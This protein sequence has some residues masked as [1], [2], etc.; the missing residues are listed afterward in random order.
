ML[1]SPLKLVNKNLASLISAAS[2][3]SHNAFPATPSNTA[4]VKGPSRLLLHSC[5]PS[6]NIKRQ[7][8]LTSLLLS[9]P[10][11]QRI[12]KMLMLSRQI[13]ALANNHFGHNMGEEEVAHRLTSLEHTYE[14][15]RESVER[16]LEEAWVGAGCLAPRPSTFPKP[17]L[18]ASQYPNSPTVDK[19]LKR[20]RQQ[21][22]IKAGKR[23][24]LSD[25]STA[26]G[27]NVFELPCQ[28]IGVPLAAGKLGP[29]HR[30]RLRMWI[31]KEAEGKGRVREELVSPMGTRLDG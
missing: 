16:E 9:Q 2:P 29:D 20:K 6:T 21:D 10:L 22:E 3:R 31:Y 25:E 15:V 18:P 26:T 27:H 14:A 23:R 4:Y 1:P 7:R 30:D 11:T 24:K 13:E 28:P 19:E 12:S 17:Q 8:P 5:A